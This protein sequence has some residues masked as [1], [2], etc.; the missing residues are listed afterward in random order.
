MN[1]IDSVQSLVDAF[2]NRNVNE[3]TVLRYV[4]DLE[5]LPEPLVVAAIRQLRRTNT[6]LP[7][8]GEIRMLVVEAGCGLPDENAAWQEVRREMADKSIGSGPWECSPLVLDIVKSIGTWEL[9]NDPDG[10]SAERFR[11]LYRERRM[12]LVKRM[13]AGDLSL[14]AALPER[15]VSALERGAA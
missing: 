14:P 12:E 6:F 11:R 10:K 7:T 13:A 4:D 5:D 8:I 3:A 15:R 1:L 2:P 9:R